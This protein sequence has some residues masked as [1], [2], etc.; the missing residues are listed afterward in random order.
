VPGSTIHDVARR[1]GVS[2]A[3][4]S[5]VQRGSAPVTDGTRRR[6]ETAI[7]ELRYRPS[8]LARGLAERRHGTVGIVFPDLSGPYFSAVIDGFE[9]ASDND[10]RGVLILSTHGREAAADRV[11]D[12]AAA[13]DGLAI[14]GRTVPDETI[15]ELRSSGL[16]VVLLA[17]PAVA[18]ADAVRAE[19]RTAAEAIT[20]HLLDVHGHRRIAFLGDP[21]SSPDGAERWEGFVAAHRQRDVAEPAGPV[22][23]SYREQE[24]YVAARAALDQPAARPTALLCANDEI[25]LGAY[26][27]AQEAGLRIGADVAVTGWDDI[28]L[29]R[30][31]SPPLTTVRQPMRELGALA[32]RTLKERIAEL[33]AGSGVAPLRRVLATRLVV[34]ESCGCGLADRR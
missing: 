10:D 8:R 32:A 16:P 29:A 28:G 21:D 7:A 25:A 23:S 19:N 6:V 17:R 22:R 12:L 27:A 3:T 31:L 15:A 13:V 1:A 4:V 5:R 9:S 14:F 2:I 20:A 18:S 30:H 24:G 33:S 11:R 26:A 34:R